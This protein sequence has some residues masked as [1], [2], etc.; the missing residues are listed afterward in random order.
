MHYLLIHFD[1]PDALETDWQLEIGGLVAKPLELSV[2]ELRKRPR[3]S[4]P[5]T[6][7]CGGNGRA[8]MDPRPISQP[9]LV[10]GIGTAEWT[11][12]PLKGLLDEAGLKPGAIE[13]VFTGADEGVQ[14]D[15][16]HFYQRSLSIEDATRDEVLIAYEM[17]GRPLE[18]Q[19]GFPLRLLVPGWYGMTSVKWL[20]SIEAVAQPFEGY[21]MIGTYRYAQ[22][23][24]D[25]GEPVTTIRVRALMV[26]PGIPDFLTRVRLVPRGPVALSGRAWAGRLEVQRVEV[27]TDGAKTWQ[28]ARLA[29]PIGKFAWRGWSFEWKA[30][31]GEYELAV[32]AT[33]SGGNIQPDDQDWNF[34]GMGNNG[35]QRV[36]VIVE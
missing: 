29:A 35:V 7:E 36:R 25:P 24:D 4:L 27:S 31:P 17:N 18:P 2:E 15:Q 8:L 22:S 3:V 10:E 26:P 14:G 11:G 6:M 16:Q 19:H 13:V 28:E 12:T 33:D 30:E 23:A 20:K 9:W 1:I 32:R 5:V 21:Q 34:Q